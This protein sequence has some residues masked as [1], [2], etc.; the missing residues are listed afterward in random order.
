MNFDWGAPGRIRFGNGTSSETSA[1]AATFGG[2]LFVVTGRD[3][4]RHGRLIAALHA[5]G[6]VGSW[7]VSGEP[8]IE[9]VFGGGEAAAAQGASVVVAV[10]GGSVL[11]AGKAIAAF[12][13]N[14]GDPMDFL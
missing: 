8:S 6:V 3:P 1:I 14:P 12:A 2:R 7:E 11:D 9:S 4:A 10:G 13:R 5:V